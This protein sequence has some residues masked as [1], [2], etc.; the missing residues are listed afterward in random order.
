MSHAHFPRPDTQALCQWG[1]MIL[2]F[3]FLN[4]CFSIS[5]ASISRFRRAC[6]MRGLLVERP[7]SVINEIFGKLA[8][9]DGPTV[10]I[11]ICFDCKGSSLKIVEVTPDHL[12]FKLGAITLM[13][14]RFILL[15]LSL[16]LYHCRT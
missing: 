14:S 9:I 5:P 3:F 8:G 15:V 1:R 11:S 6:Q 2:Q 12:F 10:T 7:N 4:K 13:S 16:F